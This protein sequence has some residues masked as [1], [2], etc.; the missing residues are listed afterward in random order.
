MLN[1]P[2][3]LP[4]PNSYDG[5]VTFGIIRSETGG[6]EVNQDR[7]YNSRRTDF[8]MQWEMENDTF[9]EWY[10]FIRTTWADWFI[11]PVIVDRTPT[12]I[13]SEQAVRITSP[14]TYTKL[15]HDWVTVQLTAELIPGDD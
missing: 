4:L 12:L 10:Q 15:G 1:Y 11:M 3:T 7:T 6:P 9:K 14:I 8:S 2:S 13:T 5:A